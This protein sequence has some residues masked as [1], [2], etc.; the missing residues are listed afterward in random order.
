MQQHQTTWKAWEADGGGAAERGPVYAEA[1]LP[2]RSG[3]SFRELDL[4]TK[5]PKNIQEEASVCK[6]ASE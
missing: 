3:K 5:R 1:T 2:H 4:N 6:R